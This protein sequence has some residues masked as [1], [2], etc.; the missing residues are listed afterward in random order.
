MR[1][2]YPLINHI[3]LSLFADVF[4]NSDEAVKQLSSSS[5]TVSCSPRWI[6]HPHWRAVGA[7]FVSS[8]TTQQQCLE[9]C[10]ARQDCVAVEWNVQDIPCWMHTARRPPHE[11]WPVVT[12]FEIVTRCDPASGTRRRRSVKHLFRFDEKQLKLLVYNTHLILF[13][14]RIS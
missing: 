10:V 13:I 3:T 6:L 9:K 12:Q 2:A 1:S 7:F 5:S 4:S 8:A 11:L 14:Y